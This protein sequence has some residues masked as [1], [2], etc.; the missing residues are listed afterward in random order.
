MICLRTLVLQ[1]GFFCLLFNGE[2]LTFHAMAY[3][4]TL[5]SQDFAWE[6]MQ[7]AKNFIALGESSGVC[8]EKL[9]SDGEGDL[10]FGKF[11]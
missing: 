3:L 2:H 5:F 7:P 10:F 9:W 11:E 1:T 4:D 8:G 6:L